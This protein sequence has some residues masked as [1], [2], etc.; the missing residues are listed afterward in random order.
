MFS[1]KYNILKAILRRETEGIDY[2]VQFFFLVLNAIIIIVSALI[3]R[4]RKKVSLRNCLFFYAFLAYINVLMT[5]TV[6]RRPSGYRSG[7]VHTHIKLG[8]GLKTGDPSFA[9]GTLSILNILLFIPLGMLLYIQFRNYKASKGIIISAVI[10]GLVSLCVEC[11]QLITGRGFF[12]TADLLTNTF[13]SLLGAVLAALF[14]K[15][16]RSL[17]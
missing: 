9:M 10:G 2:R 16:K 17:K 5:L 13:G 15:L 1:E 8:F 6:F 12:E 11:T 3:I 4:K 7:I 14:I